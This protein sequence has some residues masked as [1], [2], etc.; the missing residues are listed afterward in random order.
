MDRSSGLR[1]GSVV[2]SDIGRLVGSG[3]SRFFLLLPWWLRD[4]GWIREGRSV[5]RQSVLGIFD[6][7]DIVYCWVV[8]EVGGVFEELSM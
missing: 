3:V 7:C 5:R 1:G 2:T 8:A 6:V 4:I